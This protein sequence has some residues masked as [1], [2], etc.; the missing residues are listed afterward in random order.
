[1]VT[2]SKTS[3]WK[4]TLINIATATRRSALGVTAATS[5]TSLRVSHHQIVTWTVAS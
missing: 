2:L 3:G 4:F 5:E 1:M